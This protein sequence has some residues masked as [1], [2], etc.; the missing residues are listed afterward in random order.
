M[1]ELRIALDAHH[2]ELARQRAG[3]TG[4]LDLSSSGGPL[5][6][7]LRYR[8]VVEGEVEVTPP[9]LGESIM[10]A[11]DRAILEAGDG[12]RAGVEASL[13]R[14]SLSALHEA[15]TESNNHLRELLGAIVEAWD[16]S[17]ED[18]VTATLEAAIEN[19]RKEAIGK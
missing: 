3:L 1:I 8:Y 10:R 14:T 16:G 7:V 12:I 6:H 13:G 9:K 5:D 19:A 4:R 2:A 17:Y 11:I 18:G 15:A